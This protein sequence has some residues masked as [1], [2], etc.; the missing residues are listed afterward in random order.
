MTAHRTSKEQAYAHT[1]EASVRGSFCQG[2]SDRG[3]MVGGF[4]PFP[5]EDYLGCIMWERT[6]T[7]EDAA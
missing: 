7:S 1:V 4:S 3:S 2:N 5:M 6:E